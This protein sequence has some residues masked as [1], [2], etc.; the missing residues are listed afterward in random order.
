MKKSCVVVALACGMAC[1]GSSGGLSGTAVGSYALS[2][3]DLRPVPTM[4]SSGD[5]VLVGGAVIYASGSYAID[6]LAP[7][8]YF[9]S[10]DVIAQRDSGTWTL[11]GAQL[12]LASVYG[13]T[14][15][16]V[17]ASPTLSIK[18]GVDEWKFTKQ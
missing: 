1:N 4:T 7:S 12:H 18:Q 17:F 6:W 13:D 9:G 3:I 2:A 11:T 15:S 16:A 5:S 8:H 10:R 14:T